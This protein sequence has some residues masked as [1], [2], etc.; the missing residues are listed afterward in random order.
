MKRYPVAPLAEAMGVSFNQAMMRLGVSGSTM[1]DYRARGVTEQV[2]ERLATRAGLPA[3]YVWPELV[4][5][6]IADE[7][8]PCEE[9]GGLFVPSRRGHRFCTPKCGQRKASR[10]WARRKYQTDPVF[11]EAAKARAAKYRAAYG[12]ADRLRSKRWR[13]ANLERSRERER[14]AAR[15]RYHAKK[16]AS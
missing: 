8:V 4:D 14:E 13:D 16:E 3:A 10:E 6:R 1:Q 2:A 7:S 15:R 12:R 11:R 9:C 5:D